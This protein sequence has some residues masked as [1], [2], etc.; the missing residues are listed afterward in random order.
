M[1]KGKPQKTKY[2]RENMNSPHQMLNASSFTIG[3]RNPAM[4]LTPKYATLSSTNA[5]SKNL[6]TKNQSQ[7]QLNRSSYLLHQV[8]PSSSNTK[9]TKKQ[10]LLQ[11]THLQ[12][13]G[14][15]FKFKD[16]DMQLK[17]LQRV[18]KGNKDSY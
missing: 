9:S 15:V 2:L 18:K 8:H 1:F 16:I 14:T 11:K 10:S 17:E 7:A 5:S 3:T 4:M 6:L 13:S 12:Y